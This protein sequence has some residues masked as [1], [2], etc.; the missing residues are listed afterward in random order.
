MDKKIWFYYVCP[1]PDINL[2]KSRCLSDMPVLLLSFTLN[3]SCTFISN[4]ADL[5]RLSGRSRED[6]YFQ[7]EPAGPLFRLCQLCLFS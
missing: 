4:S 7:K 6:H 2:H 1:E 5:V 3:L